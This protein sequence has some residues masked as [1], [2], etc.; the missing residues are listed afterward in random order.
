LSKPW[1]E[2]FIAAISQMSDEDAKREVNE[3]IIQVL[4]E[5]MTDG[6]SAQAAQVKIW[7]GRRLGALA[8]KLDP[9]KIETHIYPKVSVL[10]QDIDAEVRKAMCAE[11]GLIIKALG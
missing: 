9:K 1:R 2:V 5:A 6:G 11:M 10:C 4:S 8:A 7:T 3:M